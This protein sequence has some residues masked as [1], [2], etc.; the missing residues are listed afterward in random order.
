T[1]VQKYLDLFRELARLHTVTV[2]EV[3]VST[4]ERE[5]HFE[6]MATRWEI[7]QDVLEKFIEQSERQTYMSPFQLLFCTIYSEISGGQRYAI[8]KLKEW[9][10]STSEETK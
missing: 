8:N 7:E 10:E 4:E 9:H 2:R 6:R 5:E 3:A 1:H